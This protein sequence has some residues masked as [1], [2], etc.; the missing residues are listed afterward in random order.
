VGWSGGGNKRERSISSTQ[1]M[2]TQTLDLT[3]NPFTDADCERLPTSACCLKLTLVW[4]S[5]PWKLASVINQ[6]VCLWRA[7][8]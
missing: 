6:Q 7:G 8:C 2:G 3:L 4:V 5:T 1:E